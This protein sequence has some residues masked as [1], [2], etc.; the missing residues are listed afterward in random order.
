MAFWFTWELTVEISSLLV[1]TTRMEIC[2]Y[3]SYFMN[4]RLFGKILEMNF[5]DNP[6][7][8]Q[9]RIERVFNHP[10]YNKAR[11]HPYYRYKFLDKSSWITIRSPWNVLKVISHNQGSKHHDVSGKFWPI[12]SRPIK[13]FI[14][15]PTLNRFELF[16]CSV[17]KLKNKTRFGEHVQPACMAHVGWQ[18]PEGFMCVVTGWGQTTS[19]S[20][21]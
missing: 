7:R 11:F 8:Q 15:K 9:N 20:A 5:Q 16:Y 2:W 12:C 21:R 18:L 6:E 19:S 1:F 13:R 17:L 14:P 4:F 3:D 10:L